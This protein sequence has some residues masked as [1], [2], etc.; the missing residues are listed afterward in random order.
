VDRRTSRL[1]MTV[2]LVGLLVV[3]AAVTFLGR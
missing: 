1:I 3:I 2:A